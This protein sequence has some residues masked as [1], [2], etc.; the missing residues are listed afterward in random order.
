MYAIR[1]LSETMWRLFWEAFDTWV[2]DKDMESWISSTEHIVK[3]VIENKIDSTEQ[4]LAYSL[5]LF[6]GTC[7]IYYTDAYF[8]SVRVIDRDI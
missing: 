4:V 1:I 7:P 5:Q 3:A 6:T 2:A 8:I